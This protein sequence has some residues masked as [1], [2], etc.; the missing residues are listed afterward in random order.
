MEPHKAPPWGAVKAA[1]YAA[2]DP[3]DATSR[4]AAWI[5]WMVRVRP[6]GRPGDD[7]HDLFYRL[8]QFDPFDGY[9][10]VPGDHHE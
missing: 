6:Y 3:E 9:Y 5:A 1:I 7:W 4:A 10:R 8:V 2:P